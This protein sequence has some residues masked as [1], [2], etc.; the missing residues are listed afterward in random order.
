METNFS[1]NRRTLY[2]LNSFIIFNGLLYETMPIF[3]FAFLCII[4]LIQLVS[5]NKIISAIFVI[6]TI[7]L[8]IYSTGEFRSVECATFILGTLCILKSFE[9]KNLRDLFSY[10]VIYIL[11]M[12]GAILLTTEIVAI[13]AVIYSLGAM[14]YNLGKITR[15]QYEGT[16]LGLM[17]FISCIF[18]SILYLIIP[19]VGIGT[20][21]SFSRQN[22]GTT[23]ISEELRP[24]SI[25]ELALDKSIHY[26]IE[27][28]SIPESYYWRAYTFNRTDGKRWWAR[29]NY[30]VKRSDT[31]LEYDLKVNKVG[32]KSTP[33][34]RNK[35]HQISFNSKE[36]RFRVNEYGDIKTSR[37]STSYYLS[38]DLA[39]A[40]QSLLKG[41]IHFNL[42]ERLKLDLDKL[43][44]M[45][46]EVKIYR[47]IE[48][49]KSLKL[50][51]SLSSANFDGSDISGF[52]YETKR[53]YCE[54]FASAFALALNYIG[55]KSHVVV[56]YYGGEYNK[57][58]NLLVLTGENAHAWVEYFDD[59]NWV[60]FDPVENIVSSTSLPLNEIASIAGSQLSG[61]DNDFF[62][63]DDYL[64]GSYLKLNYLFFSFDLEQQKEIYQSLK[65][66][67]EAF[68]EKY[69]TF[70]KILTTSLMIFPILILAVFLGLTDRGFYKLLKWRNHHINGYHT[71]QELISKY[72][73]SGVIKDRFMKSY[74]RKNYSSKG[75]IDL[76]SYQVL[77][78]RILL[79][80]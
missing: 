35:N 15:V 16:R 31:L 38:K 61:L 21:F 56:G 26:I 73:C 64:Y 67:F 12:A 74:L 2:L 37:S 46:D 11:F 71:M 27:V 3:Y 68:K 54:H 44:S 76:L 57:S 29:T 36:A 58:N 28:K 32:R 19:Q 42:S 72:D 55:I 39:G 13:V 8:A 7:P 79:K 53:G 30:Q 14:F 24:G 49:F 20:A 60:E 48:F 78:W 9:V 23:G 6:A 41:D 63:L 45:S 62:S 51:Y 77:K 52:L 47:L 43:K 25:A 22:S 75:E 5:R 10:Y 4:V 18:V 80:I 70:Y 40:Q 65:I 66:K 59:R 1:S 33:I 34:I 50:E 17:L 69:L